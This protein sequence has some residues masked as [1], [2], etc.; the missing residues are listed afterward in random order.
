VVVGAFVAL[1]GGSAHAGNRSATLDY[2]AT[3]EC[4]DGAHFGAVVAKRL[5]YNPFR[6]E[7]AQR[8]IVRITRAGRDL[9]GRLEWRDGT[10]GWLGDKRLPSRSGDCVELVR[11]MGLALAIQF[12]LMVTVPGESELKL[13][14]SPA[15]PPP[16]SLAPP[17]ASGPPSPSPSPPQTGPTVETIVS[18][19]PTD[20]PPEVI[21]TAKQPEAPAAPKQNDG[22]TRGRQVNQRGYLVGGG[23]GLA[24][25]AAASP[26]AVGRV[27]GAVTWAH[28]LIA[29]EGEIG[30][31]S[32]TRSA[33]GAGFSQRNLL[34][35]V[36]G[37]GVLRP[38]GACLLAK[39]GQMRVAGFGVDV[40]ATAT[41]VLAQAG[42][43]FIVTHTLGPRFEITGHADGLASLTTGTVLVDLTEAWSTPRFTA[44]IGVDAGVRFW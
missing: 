32:T 29:A 44:V 3:P 8:V 23:A 13:P 9:E 16:V 39:M 14:P 6:A 30:W 17:L 38:W 31:S 5:G 35:G 18:P 34:G 28:L 7:A 21:A 33:D 20:T 15:P 37:C 40:P 43:R 22:E 1:I 12:Q 19:A 4:P 2:H 42:V 26:I 25:G 11:A 36:A 27:F 10:G 24:L 41:A